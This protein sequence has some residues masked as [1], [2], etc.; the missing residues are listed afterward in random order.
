MANPISDFIVSRYSSAKD[1]AI[2][3]YE[4]RSIV[5]SLIIK[6]LFGDYRNSILGFGWHFVMPLVMMAVFYI[7]FSVGSSS[8][9]PDFWIYICAAIFPFNFMLSML[10]DGS[11]VI[12]DNSE[13]IKKMY[14]PREIIV[15]AKVISS[16]IITIMGYVLILG[17]IAAYG[18][19]LHIKPLLFLPLILILMAIFSLG[20]ALFFSSLTV[21]ARDFR[22]LLKSISIVFFFITPMYFVIDKVT[23]I[24]R[25]II[26]FNPLTYY[27]E[28]CQSI[29]YY[30]EIPAFDLLTICTVL[31]IISMI[32]G[33]PVFNYLKRGFAERL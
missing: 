26:Y 10:T 4:S 32:I 9:L 3:L 14:F 12:V 23:G 18:H 21:Y 30:G 7:A 8:S 6:D 24:F 33:Y 15:V 5:K 25:D 19:P 27:V 1:N 16:F 29:V 11:G 17:I 13:M 22:F 2:D 20:C 31:P 28:A